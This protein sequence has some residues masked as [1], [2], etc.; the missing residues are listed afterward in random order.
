MKCGLCRGG[1][2]QWVTAR[3]SKK[4]YN[5][6]LLTVTHWVSCV[7]SSQ[8]AILMIFGNGSKNFS[9]KC[10]WAFR[11]GAEEHTSTR[12]VSLSVNWEVFSS[13]SANASQQCSVCG[14]EGE[15]WIDRLAKH[16]TL[17]LNCTFAVTLGKMVVWDCSNTKVTATMCN[18][19]VVLLPFENVSLKTNGRYVYEWSKQLWFIKP[20]IE[21][22]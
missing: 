13:I 21:Q 3:V 2:E 20:A 10:L 6:A 1:V 18:E 22:Q 5:K 14:Q 9:N 15:I 12:T 7:L 11:D 17:T 8:H 16:R 4:N 19:F